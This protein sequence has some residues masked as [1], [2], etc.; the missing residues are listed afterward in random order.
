MSD[1]SNDPPSSPP[2]AKPELIGHDGPEV[3]LPLVPGRWKELAPEELSAF[4]KRLYQHVIQRFEN[5]STLFADW[6]LASAWAVPLSFYPGWVLIEADLRLGAQRGYADVL[7]GPRFFWCLD[8]HNDIL[9]TLNRGGLNILG[10]DTNPVAPQAMDAVPNVA[11]FPSPLDL[12]TADKARDYLRF[13]SNSLRAGGGTFRIVE[14]TDDL[15]RCGVSADSSAWAERL[16]PP[17]LQGGGEGDSNAAYVAEVTL[18]YDGS[19]SAAQ[20]QIAPDGALVMS[21]DEMLAPD[22][23]KPEEIST[24]LRRVRPVVS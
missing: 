3:R 4:F 7:I 18:Y 1:A 8:G 22:L 19:L 20:I 15:R 21:H 12:G 23:G 5:G 10:A 24:L 6:G 2:S 9:L 13:F 17:V 11:P 14:S 16:R